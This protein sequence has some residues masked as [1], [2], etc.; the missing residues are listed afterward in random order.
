VSEAVTFDIYGWDGAARIKLIQGP[1]NLTDTAMPA[2]LPSPITSLSSWPVPDP[3]RG[4]GQALLQCLNGVSDPN[5]REAIRYAVNGDG[6]IYFKFNSPEWEAQAWE[7]LWDDTDFFLLRPQRGM[8]RVV[9]RR[10]RS[11][12]IF[13]LEQPVRIMA[14]LSAAGLSNAPQWDALYR[15]ASNHAASADGIALRLHVLTG[16][17]ALADRI[18][19]E[20]R[21]SDRLS[22]SV[23]N[24]DAGRVRTISE[25]IKLFRPHILHF[26]CHGE[27]VQG[28]G[29]LRISDIDQHR[30]S[31]INP[32]PA[33]GT[34]TSFAMDYGAFREIIDR[35]RA[36]GWLWLTVLNACK[37][38][39]NA[40][41]VARLPQKLA[42][43]G[44]PVAIGMT[45]EID[46]TDAG[47]FCNAFYASVFLELA[48]ISAALQTADE[49][50]LDWAKLL[51]GPRVSIRDTRAPASCNPQWTFPVMYVSGDRD[52]R[53]KRASKSPA[54]GA[55]ADTSGLAINVHEGAL[56]QLG[57]APSEFLA[58]IANSKVE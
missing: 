11:S 17:E 46:E 15:A 33:D 28:A 30:E 58:L 13:E 10:D 25:Q 32:Q 16:E 7:A 12:P 40:A 57:N 45:E 6:T 2:P 34:P 8:A 48:S 49:C 51:H 53:F 37:L 5:V 36:Q 27:I 31:L 38:A 21:K 50:V 3:V 42:L 54:R 18:R 20:I 29:V 22:V 56:H 55:P 43:A 35:A 4:Y 24:I 39:A 1:P 44:V 41:N 19:D 47:E 26:F 14:V 52:F 9:D 23:T